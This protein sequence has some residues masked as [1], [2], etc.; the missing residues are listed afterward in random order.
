[1]R[2]AAALLLTLSVALSACGGDG[3]GGT[4]V[5]AP[6]QKSSKRSGRPAI[7]GELSVTTTGRLGD[8]MDDELSGLVA[9]RRQDGVLWAIEDSGNPADLIALREDGTKLGRFTVSGAENVD[10]EDVA[11]AGSDLYVADIGDNAEQRSEVVV[12][13]VPEPDAATGGGPTAPPARI[14]LAYPDGAHD[15]EA[16]LVDPRTRELVVV[17]KDLAGVGRIYAAPAE[18]GALRLV[19]G[20][21]FGLGGAVTAGSVSPDGRTVAVR[22]Y[23]GVF[24]WTRKRGE[25]LTRTLRRAPCRSRTGLDEGQGEAL[26]L[27]R[28]G[29]SFLT[30]TEGA[31]APVRRY[32]A[33]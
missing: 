21:D 20:R 27:L 28:G 7:C 9:S 3:G 25:R 1:M 12:Y 32:D 11:L 23:T 30:V 31:N 19:A 2:R 24:A 17:T 4:S 6:R 13:R 18:G 26:A 22:T 16:L 10:W 8:V 15:A 14:A 33:R 5:E 29:R